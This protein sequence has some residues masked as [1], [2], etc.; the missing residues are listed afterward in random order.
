MKSLFIFCLVLIAFLSNARADLTSY[1]PEDYKIKHATI[2]LAG[3]YAFGSS[4]NLVQLPE[5]AR[6]VKV[7]IGSNEPTDPAINVLGDVGIT[8]DSDYYGVNAYIWESG[9]QKAYIWH[10]PGASTYVTLTWKD[11]ADGQ[12]QTPNMTGNNLEVFVEFVQE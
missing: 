8:S 11:T 1:S 4:L 7:T 6:I 5:N 10:K 2:S 12:T 3:P 9:F